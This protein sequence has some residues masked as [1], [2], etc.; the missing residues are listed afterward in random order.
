MNARRRNE[1]ARR[2][3]GAETSRFGT[4]ERAQGDPN[5]FRR[6]PP[7]GREVMDALAAGDSPNVRLYAN[8]PD[9]WTPARA[10]R[11]AFGPASTLVLSPGAEPEGFTWPPVRDLVGNVT[12][13]DG[14]S[15]RALAQALVRDGVR[16]AYLLDASDPARNV[17]VVAR[18]TP[19]RRAA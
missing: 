18:D 14:E 8:R 9:P 3:P 12:G 10:H 7:Y 17:R 1:S 6:L 13:L 15:V 2:Q 16:L 19:Q 5:A 4:R 11:A